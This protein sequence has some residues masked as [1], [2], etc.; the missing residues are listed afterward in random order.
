MGNKTSRSIHVFSS[1][2]WLSFPI[3]GQPSVI[4]VYKGSIH[5]RFEFKTCG[6]FENCKPDWSCDY[7]D[8]VIGVKYYFQ[9]RQIRTQ[10]V[11][12]TRLYD[13]LNTLNGNTESAPIYGSMVIK[14]VIRRKTEANFR[15]VTVNDV[16]AVI[17]L[18]KIYPT[19][20]HILHKTDCN[21]SFLDAIMDE[22]CPISDT[23]DAIE[24][25][26]VEP[27]S[28][29]GSTLPSYHTDSSKFTSYRT[30]PFLT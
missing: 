8:W 1:Q 27:P 3:D 2:I 15:V 30:R 21:L 11:H 10:N 25:L 26:S 18:L 6:F 28:T 4:P 7:A 13:T 19:L 12:A 29:P 14:L 9:R 5:D 17:F 22:F 20:S 16:D 24:T 23:L